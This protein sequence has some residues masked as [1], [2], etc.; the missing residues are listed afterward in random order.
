[1]TTQPVWPGAGAERRALQAAA[2]DLPSGTSTVKPISSAD[3]IRAAAGLFSI[4]SRE[5]PGQVDRALAVA[6][7]DE[8]P[9]LL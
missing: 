4:S 7:Q 9:A 8:R 1:M 2:D 6:D 5:Q 3:S